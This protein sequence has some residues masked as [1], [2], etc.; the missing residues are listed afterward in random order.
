MFVLWSESKKE[1]LNR[2]KVCRNQ[3]TL[4]RGVE[5]EGMHWKIDKGSRYIEGQIYTMY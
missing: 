5:M 3:V 1:Y 2:D 4:G